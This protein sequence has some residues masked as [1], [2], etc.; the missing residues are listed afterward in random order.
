MGG[1]PRGAVLPRRGR[2]TKPRASAARRAALGPSTTGNRALKAARSQTAGTQGALFVALIA[3]PSGC[4]LKR[5]ASPGRRA[6]GAC[7]GLWDSAPLGPSRAKRVLAQNGLLLL[8]IGNGYGFPENAL[9]E[10]QGATKRVRYQ[11]IPTRSAC[12][13]TSRFKRPYFAPPRRRR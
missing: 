2:I 5:R 13:G 8:P 12:A 6:C 3:P 1:C 4:G 7:P 10:R 11:S 9:T